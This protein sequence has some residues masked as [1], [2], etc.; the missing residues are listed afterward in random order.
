MQCLVL[1]DTILKHKAL[2][3]QLR[4]GLSILGLQKEMEKAPDKFNH[5]FVHSGEEVS[6]AYVK[7]LLKP[8]TSDDPRGNN[9]VQMLYSFIQNSSKDDLLDFLC[10]TTG[11][12]SNT[13]SFFPGSI[14]VSIGNT[15][16]FLLQHVV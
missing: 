2:L 12:K 6:A 4:K 16:C 13:A 7:A 8:P 14:T 5:F 3:D 9:V 11:S 1:R 10:F 15:E